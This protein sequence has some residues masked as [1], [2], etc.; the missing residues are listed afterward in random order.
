MSK[1]ENPI[2]AYYM[3]LDIG[4][5]HDYTAISVIE[6]RLGYRGWD[7]DLGRYEWQDVLYEPDEV[8]YSVTW[9]ERL[10]LQMSYPDMV[11]ICAGRFQAIDTAGK[12]SVRNDNQA[13]K[14]LAVDATGVGTP[15]VDLLKKAG[16]E[17]ISISITGGVDVSNTGNDYRVPK[18]DL[19]T[20]VQVLQQQRRLKVAPGLV[21]G[22]TL[23]REMENFSYKISDAG[24]DSYG[25]WREGTHDDL[26]LSVACALWAA[27]NGIGVGEFSLLGPGDPWYDQ[28]NDWDER[29]WQ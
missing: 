27:S 2:V 5:K 26:V 4:Q 20:S 16:L 3:G 29:G 12:G 13:H 14:T 28:L 15:V 24:H 9:L 6:A 19:V 22:Q 10:P 21:E 23:A 1:A 17:P 8:I 7:L 11:K 25:A 18:R